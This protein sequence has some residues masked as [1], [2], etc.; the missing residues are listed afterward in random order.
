MNARLATAAVAAGVAVGA[1]ACSGG[2]LSSPPALE[3][4]DLAAYEHS[5]VPIVTDGGRVVELGMKPGIEDL[6]RLHIVPARVI[7]SEGDG[8]LRS[9]VEVRRRLA[10]VHAPA[11][12]QAVTHW[13]LL[14]LSGYADAAR[15]FA[16]A[17]RSQ[18]SAREAALRRGVA[19]ASAADRTYDQGAALLQ[20]IRRSLGLR[21]SA[22]FPGG[23]S[24]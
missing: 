2:G 6:E 18:G 10:Q 9:L 4:S 13:F 11:R 16:Q 19:S 23:S 21:P 8:W 7:A 1:V 24:G 12:L 5:V 20:S 15:S 22:S 14:A 3:R 17:A